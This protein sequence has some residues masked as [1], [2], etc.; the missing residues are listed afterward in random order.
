MPESPSESA[1]IEE[2]NQMLDVVAHHVPDQDHIIT[3][4]QV[5]G[6]KEYSLS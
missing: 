5:E 4:S 2:E 6:E 3:D 1:S